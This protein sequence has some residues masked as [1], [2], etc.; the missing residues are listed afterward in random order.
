M[1]SMRNNVR[2]IGNVGQDPEIKVLNNEKKMALLS[3]ATNETYKNDRG[4][5]VEETQWHRLVAWGNQAELIEKYVQKGKELAIE[6][7][8]VHRSY[9]DDNNQ[10]RYISE[11]VIQDLLFI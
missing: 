9:E 1:S 10:K 3:L 4:D 8:L 5:K 7:K 11:V 6:G 2:L